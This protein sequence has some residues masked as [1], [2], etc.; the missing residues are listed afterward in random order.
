M[1]EQEKHEQVHKVLALLSTYRG[2]ELDDTSATRQLTFKD[3]GLSSITL[4]YVV[5]E[6]E[7][8]LDRPFDFAAFAGVD[9]VGGLLRAIGLD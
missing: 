7:E 9:S 8:R 4:A 6:L 3:V 5:V 1:S 2:R